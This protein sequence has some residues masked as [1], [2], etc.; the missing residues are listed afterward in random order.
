MDPSDKYKLAEIT[1][2]AENGFIITNVRTGTTEVE[3]TKVW[4]DDNA[5]GDR[6]DSVTVELYQNQTHLEGKDAII[7][8]GENGE[9]AYIFE[10]L[11]AFDSE[12]KAYDYTVKEVDLD[13]NY[14]LEGITGNAKDGF[15]ITNIRTGTTEVNA[16]KAWKDEDESDRP[17]KVKVQ[18]YQNE[19]HLEDEDTELTTDNWT[20]TFENLDAFDEAGKA[21]NYTVKEVDLDS[22]YKLEGITGN[23]TDGFVIT[24]VRTGTTEVNVTKAWKDQ[25]ESARPDKVNVQLYQNGNHLEDKDVELTVNNWA[26]TFENLEGFD[27]AGKAY[28]YTV[29]EVG[30]DNNY[31]LGSI[32]GNATDGFTI[33]NVRTGKTSIDITKDWQ[34]DEDA[35]EDRPD[36]IKVNV[37]QD[38]DFYEEHELSKGN[39]WKLQVENLPQFDEEGKAFTYTVKEHDV[40]GYASE[41]DG[42]EITNTRSDKKD[43]E[44]SKTWFDDN[45]DDRP[46]EI[47]VELYKSI[48]DGDKEL[49]DKYT[50]EA[51]KDWTHKVKD[52]PVF[53][54]DGKAYTYEI[55]EV[56]VDGYETTIN[57]F[58]IT[59]L[60]VGT[61]KVTGEKT[62]VEVDEQY[63]PDA[64]TVNLISNGNMCVASADVNADNDW[65]YNFTDL[66]KYDKE[67]KEI[68]YTIEEV[69]VP[70]YVSKVDGYNIT[71][72]QKSTEVS[73]KKIWNEVDAQYRPDSITVNLLANDVAVVSQKVELNETGESTFTFAELA[74]YDTDGNEIDYTIV[75][76]QVPGYVSKVDGYNITNTQESTEVTGTKTWI[77]VD[78]QYR[79]DSIIV[80]LLANNK[81]I[82]SQDVS[83]NSDGEWSF[84]FTELAK[85]DIEGNEIVYTVV[86]EKVPGYVSEVDGTNITN[87]QESREV[88]GTKSWDEVDEQYR[89]DSITVNL[90]AG[91]EEIASKEVEADD[92]GEW[93]FTFE[94]LP[95]YDTD[96][97][98]IEYTIEEESVTGYTSEIEDFTITN[99]QETTEL[100]GVKT[101]LDDNSQNRPGTIIVQVK[102]G[103]T[104]VQAKDVT[105]DDEGE[106]NYTFTDL[107]KYDKE[108]NEITYT[109]DEAEVPAGYEKSIEGNNITNLRVGTTEIEVTKL[110]QDEHEND[111]PETITINL[112]QNG[113]AHE[114]Y[115]VKETD[116]WKLT[117]KDL[118]QYDEAGKAYKY[119]VTEHDVPGYESDVDGFKI[120]NTRSDVKSIKI[121][122]SWLDNDS[123]SRPNSI[124]VELFRS[125]TDGE[126]ELVDTY[127]VTANN[128]WSL[129]VEN[130]PSFDNDGKAYTYKI[131]EVAV[132]GYETTINGFD[133]TNLRVGT[134]NVEGTKT[135]KKDR[136][137]DRP[138]SIK[139][140]L[141]QNGKKKETKEV[142][143]ADN[144]KIDFGK[145]PKYDA[146]GKA[147]KYTF[148]EEKVVGY[149]TAYNG[150][151]ITNTFNLKDVKLDMEADP[152]TIVA[153][154]KSTSELTTKVTD[155][156][157]K[158]VEGVEV[159]FEAERGTFPDGNTG[160]TDKDGK[161]KVTFKSEKIED[162]VSHEI[163]VKATVRDKERGLKGEDEITMTF[164][165]SSITGVVTDNNTGKPI[166]GAKI[167]VTDPNSSFEV[168]YVTGPDGKYK[169]PIPKGE[170]IYDVEITKTIIVNNKPEEIT[171]KQKA[172]PGKIDPEKKDEEF[173]AEK[174]FVGIVLL[175]DKDGHDTVIKKKPGQKYI[176][177]G[178]TP[179]GFGKQGEIN[180]SGVFT[181]EELEKGKEYQFAIIQEIDG[182]ELIMGNITV[183]IDTDGEISVHE[184]LI[185]PY[186]TITD[187]D[188]GDI[189]GGAEVELRY[190]DTERNRKNGRIPGELVE[191][192][193]L[194]DFAP[195]D[196]KNTQI[197][198]D[199]PVWNDEAG[200][201]GN[202]AWMVFPEADYYIVSKK[203]GYKDYI[204]PMISVEYEIVRHD[205]EMERIP[206]GSEPEN[207]DD[208]E[209][210]PPIESEPEDPEE[211]EEPGNQSNQDSQQPDDSVET[212]TESDTGNVIPNTATNIF[213]MM[214]L[215]MSLLTIGL[216]TL[217]VKK[218]KEV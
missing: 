13:S 156:D 129:E 27:E 111:R 17:G 87:T 204:S 196:N 69:E 21:Y 64:I 143:K 109:I 147:Y 28:D 211:Q 190:A 207:P 86:E 40:A 192:P 163:P 90:L 16:T 146:N 34:D 37:L 10:N 149:D 178:I 6:P 181:I 70:G 157:G 106:W 18:L 35:T 152:K 198:V 166:E 177:K 197:S 141:F 120:T 125:V 131:E 127:T 31:K 203:L 165:P 200:G 154:G 36:T 202:Y 58:D 162:T 61:T 94:G 218:R 96:G 12:G 76:D 135:W 195:N 209:L 8:A 216:V 92:D 105:A 180:E 84:A 145:H 185:D 95:K 39:N 65:T 4:K 115:E 82:D 116:D 89:P 49:V 179:N 71:N 171:F 186:G 148:T 57:G 48:A 174:T 160:I 193:I 201:H 164:E 112:L 172:K 159:V 63:R 43:I 213:N 217:R 134:T 210:V 206:E 182:K 158:P 133:I 168:E 140:N 45:A 3:V 75:E 81:E 100:S 142:T 5:I 83:A 19:N 72:T 74:K 104:V 170:T 113:T 189:I 214:L 150:Y 42:F 194:L 20:H 30:L 99:T 32:T 124:D 176:V 205:F 26:H 47:A 9:W 108:G 167:V 101:W 14:K 208:D 55:E 44:I 91:E 184:E 23:A 22:N 46:T 110:W 25:D 138:E 24:N 68:K 161:A 93:N 80:N 215:G 85:Y 137:T 88:T 114:A 188:T 15:V 54:T 67:G 119:T 11:D 117:V 212:E 118:P 132:D 126:Q 53:N 1:G 29:K 151:N 107:P 136:E 56:A 169:I 51:D 66:T 38:G 130:L 97:N 78:E 139:V 103:D 73:G 2:N 60:R 175:K 62:W 199:T 153:D 59:N 33:T 191:L 52:L 187:K 102:N 50:L 128:D 155:E 144:W 173:P 77:E 98:E 123:K 7:T 79:P 121:S 41:V 122:K 183:T